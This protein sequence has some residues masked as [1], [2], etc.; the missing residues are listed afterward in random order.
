M[1]VSWKHTPDKIGQ[2]IPTLNKQGFMTTILDP[3]TNT[4]IRSLSN[5]SDPVLEIGAAYGIAALIG[6]LLL[7]LSSFRWW[8][9]RSR[10]G[11]RKVLLTSLLYLPVL[12]IA[13]TIDRVWPWR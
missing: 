11:A 5:N 6:G 10:A 2:L 8:Q 3:Y 13:V 4:F 9:N 12:L 7:I 1:I